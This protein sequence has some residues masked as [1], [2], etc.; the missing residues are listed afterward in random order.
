MCTTR[1]DRTWTAS[2]AHPD[3]YVAAL[4]GPTRCAFADNG[5]R[6]KERSSVYSVR[7]LRTGYPSGM[8]LLSWLR[9]IVVLVGAGAA[10]YGV[11]IL[12][13]GRAAR[14]DQRAFRRSTDAGRYYLCFGSALAFVAL[15]Q[16]LNERHQRLLAGVALIGT[17]VLLG[18]AV[19]YRPRDRKPR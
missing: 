2:F 18:L 16:L 8:D 1:R 9:L 17:V 7:E 13:T 6:V 5:D 19:R 4:A 10:V 15:S 14:G 3:T 12:V 11:W